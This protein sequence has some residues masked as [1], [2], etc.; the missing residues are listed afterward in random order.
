MYF[1]PFFCSRDYSYF[2]YVYCCVSFI[3]YFLTC[4]VFG[5]ILSSVT[6]LLFWKKYWSI[7]V[8]FKCVIIY[9]KYL[10]YTF[11]LFVLINI[12][13][14]FTS[15]FNNQIFLSLNCILLRWPFSIFITLWEFDKSCVNFFQSK[16][17]TI[18]PPMGMLNWRWIFEIFHDSFAIF[19]TCFL[20]YSF[21]PNFLIIRI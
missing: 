1:I 6:I 16:P 3:K 14:H 18:P 12:I 21:N 7:S 9:E 8:S 17:Y 2:W 15:F 10:I 5:A 13:V 4:C 20:I 19:Y 11:L